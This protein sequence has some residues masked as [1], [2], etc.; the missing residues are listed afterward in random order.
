MNNHE[1]QQSL[2]D[3]DV[4]DQHKST[5]DSSSSSSMPRGED[6]TDAVSGDSSTRR[7]GNGTGLA[8]RLTDLFVGDGDNDDDL[9]IQRS[10]QGTVMQ[11]LQ[12]LDMQVMGACRADERLKPLLKLNVSS[13]VAED[14]LLSHL[15]QHFEP[16]EVG[17]LARCLCVPLMSVR[18]GKI[19]KQGTLLIPNSARGNLTLSLLPTS[20]LRISFI[21]DDGHV[22]RLSTL[23]NTS[24]CSSVMIEGISADNCG[25]SFMIRIPA[26]DEPF[27][28]WCSEKSMLLGN[29]LLDKM[30]NL[31]EKKPSLA[32]LTGISDSRLD[33]F[34]NRLR[35]Y[36]VG[37]K[38]QV[39]NNTTLV[40]SATSSSTTSLGHSGTGK[41]SQSASKSSRVRICSIQGSLS[42]KASSFKEGPPRNLI[43]LKNVVR[44]KFRRKGETGSFS[45]VENL[46]TISVSSPSSTN[47]STP[48]KSSKGK[49]SE[50]AIDTRMFP[51]VTG[52][53]VGL[54]E[55]TVDGRRVVSSTPPV[56][57]FSPYYCWCPPVASALQYTVASSQMMP[58]SATEPFTLPPLS[59]ILTGSTPRSSSSSSSLLTP[60]PT[61]NLDE[62]PP[63]LPEPLIRL[64]ISVSTS[65]QIPLFTPLMTDPIVHIPVIDICSSGQAYLVSGG[66]AMNVTIPPL[67]Q[68]LVSPLIQETDSIAEK[69]ARDTLR[70][71]ISGS[72]QLPSVLAHV[73]GNQNVLASG[74]RGLYGGAT[75]VNHAI[76][77]SIA[78]MGLVSLSERSGGVMR[79]CI[80]EGD[81]VDLLGETVDSGGTSPNNDD[82]G[83]GAGKSG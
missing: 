31:L 69:S 29:E 6:L 2:G 15:S 48:N 57:P 39:N 34:A 54:A 71:L 68:A 17:L 77:N 43:S 7:N 63:F 49:I 82:P 25:R 59:S 72:S 45:C 3:R 62:I 66:P 8:A 33:C 38:T 76:A 21:G 9:L 75:D 64:P 37:S 53:E 13:G 40:S 58:M 65:Q 55:K 46:D 35:T 22:E 4:D 26:I 41:S 83:S 73:D 23:R 19:D 28:F 16:S 12:A 18:V 52:L 79:R 51:L 1:K 10:T 67:H 27:Y 56:P 50:S 61:L 24:D 5:E 42:P 11:W 14:R 80:E 30:K 20:D 47:T 70:L 60:K 81:L 44:D 78:A 32:D 36:L 74:S